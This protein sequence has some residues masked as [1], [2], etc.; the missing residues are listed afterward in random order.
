MNMINALMC[1][2]LAILFWSQAFKHSFL[3]LIWYESNQ[4]TNSLS[5][6]LWCTTTGLWK[7]FV[8]LLNITHLKYNNLC[9]S[10]QWAEECNNNY[11]LP[12]LIVFISGWAK[13]LKNTVTHYD[14][15]ELV[16]VMNWIIN[17]PTLFKTSN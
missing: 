2:F 15:F 14:N 6:S 10:I 1:L 8:L 12:H 7:N 9:S 11:K 3:H 16:I 4:S 17:L 13:F 5:Q